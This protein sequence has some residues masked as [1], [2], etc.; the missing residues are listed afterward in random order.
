MKEYPSITKDII[1][2]PIFG[3]DKLDGSS[4]RSEWNAKRGFYKFGSR[5]QLI[6][7][8][9]PIVGKSVGVIKEKYEKDLHDLFK[10]ERFESVICFFEFWGP[11]SFAGQH[12]PN[13][14]QTVT[15]FDVNPYKKGILDPKEYLKLVGHLDIAKLLFQ[16][17]PNSQFIE[18]VQ[19]GM[20]SGMTFEG[21]ICKAKNLKRTPMPLMFK[22]KNLAWLE[23]L[24]RYCNGD[25]ALFAKLA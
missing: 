4:I 22:I 25:E 18:L 19:N 3:F 6:D 2:T 1:N 7:E 14:N 10:K 17:N 5:T 11:S 8:K 20:L 15:L 9:T 23:K 16:G 24:K 21:V 13:E 12:D